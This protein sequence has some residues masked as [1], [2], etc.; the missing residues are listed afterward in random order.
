V[1][2]TLVVAV[3]LAVCGLAHAQPVEDHEHGS[4]IEQ[5]LRMVQP[6]VGW[7][8]DP[9]LSS[10]HGQALAAATHFDGLVVM[11]SAEVWQPDQ[12]DVTL[13]VSRVVASNSSEAQL[14]A[15][16]VAATKEFDRLSSNGIVASIKLDQ[17]TSVASEIDDAAHGL[18]ARLMIARDGKRLE[19]VTVECVWQPAVENA[20]LA[21][22]RAALATATATIGARDRLPIV[23][24]YRSA[25]TNRA[26][27]TPPSID[28]VRSAP[29]M[30]PSINS[31]NDKIKI[32]PLVIE[33]AAAPFNW[34]PIAF[35]AGL[36]VMAIAFWLNRRHRLKLEALDGRPIRRRR[37][38]KPKD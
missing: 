37:S 20:N 38:D 12:K 8:M 13:R 34:R 3:S 24:A 29:V 31:G 7:Q 4:H 33:P 1:K 30:S 11:S 19:A 23:E 32:P 15:A 22:C 21:A 6:P 35:G 18:V 27:A 2:A 36:V 9:D 25:L 26:A 5:L 10:T 16:V 14:G 28:P 17:L